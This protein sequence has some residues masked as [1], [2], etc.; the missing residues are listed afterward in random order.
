MKI[1]GKRDGEKEREK[2][3]KRGE[4]IGNEGGHAGEDEKG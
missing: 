2:K 1:K 4:T 3:K